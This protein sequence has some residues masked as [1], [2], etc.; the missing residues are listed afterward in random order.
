MFNCEGNERKVSYTID[1]L[2]K[3]GVFRVASDTDAGLYDRIKG[4]ELSSEVL[5]E[6][7]DFVDVVGVTDEFR[8][9]I[10]IFKPTAGITPAGFRQELEFGG[11]KSLRINLKRDIAF[12]EN[13]V[14]RPTNVL[15]SANTAN[16]FEVMAMKNLI[17]NLTTNPQIIYSNFLNN[18]N[19]NVGNQ[20]KDRFEVLRELKNLVGSGVDIS[21]ELNDPFA[22]KAAIM[23]EIAQFE[24]V[25]SRYQLV[26]KVPHTGPINRENVKDFLAGNYGSYDQGATKDFFYGHNLAYELQEKGYRVNFTLMAEPHQT[27]LALLAKPYFINA[28]IQRR[29]DQTHKLT[30]LLN[31]LDETGDAIYEEEIHDFMMKSDMLSSNDTNLKGAVEKARLLV[32][33]RNADLSGKEDGL[34]SV[35]HSLRVLKTANLPDTRLIVCNMKTAQMYYDLDRLVTEPEFAD[36]KQRV[37]ITCEPDY[38]AQFTASPTIYCYQRSFLNSV[39]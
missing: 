27:A 34:D 23:E 5:A 30:S 33:Y 29:N 19:A 18:P 7:K 2:V 38:F 16:P 25:L 17:A 36:M 20:F 6:I 8:K 10:E 37:I 15:Y 1:S 32:D 9:V 28:F 4:I 31:R 13:S 22:D 39:K 14:R 21:V 24:E 11:D 26:V 35:R 12:M 3:A